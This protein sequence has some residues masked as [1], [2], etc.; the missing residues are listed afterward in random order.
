MEVFEAEDR[1]KILQVFKEFRC[2]A[3]ERENSNPIRSSRKKKEE[4]HS[5][6]ETFFG[7]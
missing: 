1:E 6:L 3:V 7:N 5:A 2:E 4:L